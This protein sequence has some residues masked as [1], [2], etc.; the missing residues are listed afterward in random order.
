METEQLIQLIQAVAASGLTH[1]K[2]E[3]K[4]I[5][6]VLGREET[7]GVLNK[8]PENAN[9]GTGFAGHHVPKTAEG[10][11]TAEEMQ[12][13]PQQEMQKPSKDPAT[14]VEAAAQNS[15]EQKEE[16]VI[17]TSPLV[18][19]FYEAPAE[20]EDP[21]VKVGDVV[22][23]GQMLAIVE[24]MKL[25]NDIESDFAGTVAEIYVTNGEAVSYGQPLFRIVE[26]K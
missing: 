24:A 17:V 20:G 19:T 13:M 18:G 12:T 8:A 5:K 22:A 25:M 9:F 21:Y 4:G 3:E 23:K 1:F 16:G 15:A 10:G 6:L 26:G 2:Y 11:L 7:A 14:A